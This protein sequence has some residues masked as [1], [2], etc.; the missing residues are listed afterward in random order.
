MSSGVN[1]GLLTGRCLIFFL[2]V[3]PRCLANNPLE[4]RRDQRMPALA[5]SLYQKSENS[6]PWVKSAY[7]LFG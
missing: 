7:H 5:Q 1:T 2:W 4:E 3:Q 6:G